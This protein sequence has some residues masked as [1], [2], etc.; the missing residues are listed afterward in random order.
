M[1]SPEKIPDDL[2]VSGVK[3]VKFDLSWSQTEMDTFAGEAFGA[4]GRIDV[5]VNNAAFAYMGAIEESEC[6]LSQ[7]LS[8]AFYR[9]AVPAMCY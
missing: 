4:F 2:K 6:V 9:A 5:V 8:H 1:R 3:V 7:P